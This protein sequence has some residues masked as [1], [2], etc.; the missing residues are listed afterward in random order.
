MTK[1]ISI[2]CLT[3]I[4]W[5]CADNDDVRVRKN[6]LNLQL[7]KY[8]VYRTKIIHQDESFYYLSLLD[9]AWIERD[10]II[11]GIT[12]MLQHSTRGGDYYFRDSADCVLMRQLSNEQIIY[13]ENLRDTLLKNPPVYKVVT[14]VNKIVQ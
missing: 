5:G 12:Y 13:S 4:F 7:G 2:F 14:D 3:L 6:L 11:N 8:W 10:T 1:F 9:S